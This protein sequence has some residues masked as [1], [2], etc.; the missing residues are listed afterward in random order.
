MTDD[1]RNVHVSISTNSLLCFVT[2]TK[3]LQHD[4]KTIKVNL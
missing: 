3:L 2:V 4:I 1:A